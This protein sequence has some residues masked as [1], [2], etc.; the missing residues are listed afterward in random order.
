MI[1]VQEAFGKITE[2]ISKGKTEVI[3]TKKS[4][5]QVIA[6]DVFSPIHMPPFNQ[7]AMDGYALGDIDSKVYNLVGE[8]KAGDSSTQIHLKK[9]EA[10][11]I[12]T[13]GMVPEGSVTVV[14]Q[15]IVEA[16]SNSIQLKERI[17]INQNIRPKGEQIKKDEIALK[18]GTVIDA[19]TIGYL[20]GIG[21]H[22]INVYTK[23]KTIVIATG[24][25]LTKPGEQLATGKIYESNTYTIQAALKEIGIEATIQTVEDDYQSTKNIIQDAIDQYDLVIMTGG[26]SVGDYDFVGKAFNEIGV[27]QKFY[28][29]KQKPGKP[30]YFGKKEETTVFGLPGNPAAALSCF[31]LYVIPAIKKHQGYTQ[32]SLEKRE[33]SLSND[34]SKT[35]KLSH[36]LKGFHQGKQVEVLNSQSSA[37]LSSFA[38]ANCLIFLEEGKEH[39]G[40]GENVDVYI[41]P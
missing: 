24:N 28:K 21:V 12:F 34:Y 19:G 22:Q 20:Y 39:W 6:N 7:S 40:K 25:E 30:I 1:S 3:E 16:N 15:E 8:I 35:K 38:T 23:P 27:E 36:F 29:V 26:I 2:N 4:L 9:G 32:F 14:K 10:I 37:M 11:R 13:G 31:Y 33:L 17:N 18:K 5:G 41:L